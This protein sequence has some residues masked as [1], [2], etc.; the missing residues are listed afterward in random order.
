[1]AQG[2]TL[3]GHLGSIPTAL[4][5]GR[6]ATSATTSQPGDVFILNDPF[7]G[8]MHLPDIFIFKPIFVEGERLAFAATVCHHTDVGGRVAGL[9]RLGSTEIYQEGLRIP[10]LK[11]Y[12]RGERNETLF[13]LI[14][15][16]VRAAGARCSATCAPSSPPAT[17]PSGSSSSWSARYGARAVDALHGRAASTTPSA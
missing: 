13:A 10:P 7:E 6:C 14:E 15:K 8:G 1:M 4:A 9:E 17:S 12:E 2:L 16:N 3:P 11:L 5:G